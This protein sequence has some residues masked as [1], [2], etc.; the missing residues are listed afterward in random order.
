MRKKNKESID[1]TSQGLLIKQKNRKK[2]QQKNLLIVLLETEPKKT[3]VRVEIKKEIKPPK[4]PK[5]ETIK[6]PKRK[7]KNEI[8]IDEISKKNKK[9]R[10]RSK[11]LSVDQ[12]LEREKRKKEK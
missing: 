5:K 6:A 2:L 12:I 3:K 10:K 1:E 4:P 9:W 11:K 7:R 8:N